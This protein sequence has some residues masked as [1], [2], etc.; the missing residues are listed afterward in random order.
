MSCY[1]VEE[2]GIGSIRQ[3]KRGKSHKLERRLGGPGIL[4]L[5]IVK[6]LLVLRRSLSANYN[7]CH[8]YTK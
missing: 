6:K 8:P 4:E 5:T 1:E 2:E 3:S 7:K